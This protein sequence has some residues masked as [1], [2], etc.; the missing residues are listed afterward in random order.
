VSSLALLEQLGRELRRL[1]WHRHLERARELYAATRDGGRAEWSLEH[2]TR[3][4]SV[5]GLGDSPLVTASSCPR[6]PPPA[7]GDWNGSRTSL[8][9]P[10]RWVLACSKCGAE[11]V[12]NQVSVT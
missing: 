10:D 2:A 8:H 4:A 3:L 9:L 6:C 12:I 5:L 7:P 1:G 11:W